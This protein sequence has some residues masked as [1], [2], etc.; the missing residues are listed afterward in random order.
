MRLPALVLCVAAAASAAAQ[1]G[2]PAPLPVVRLDAAGPQ[3][4]GPPRP[5]PLPVS[6]IDHLAG[7][8]GQPSVTLSIAEPM[9][10]RDMLRLL[11]MGTPLS[12]V[13]DES[14][15]GTFE[16]DLRGLTLRQAIEAVLF[17]RS[18]DYDV[19]GTVIRVYPRRPLTRLF[20]VDRVAARRR[21]AGDPMQDLLD[22]V[23]AL[24]STS[25]RVYL[26]RHAGVLQATDYADRLEQV[27]AYLE[28]VERRTARQVRLDARVL[29]IVPR[30]GAVID[31]PRV[32]ASA[33]GRDADSLVRALGEQAAVTV[34]ASPHVT[35]LHNEPAILR[36]TAERSDFVP[37]GASPAPAPGFSIVITPQIAANGIVQMIV[38]PGYARAAARP[39]DGGRVLTA[40]A[41][42]VVRVDDGE[43]AVIAGL[44][45]DRAEIVILVT[46]GTRAREGAR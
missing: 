42:S 46:A 30:G 25:G 31:W 43:T 4:P 40:R 36:V 16:G 11:L 33:P 26:D 2:P 39:E 23:A 7:L 12:V 13:L 24:L 8:D 41:E 32:R 5:A 6:R 21:A 9:P 37:G 10:L 29:E 27:G 1:S 3:T 38:A 45:F 22:G 19:R 20:D 14:V 28:A 18:L 17:T 35:T 44:P 15:T 34:L